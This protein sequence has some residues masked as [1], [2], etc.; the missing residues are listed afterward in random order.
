MEEKLILLVSEHP[1]LYQMTSP[2]YHNVNL[3]N[4]AW[5]N[6]SF[7]VGLPVEKCRKKWKYLRDTYKREKNEEK[8]R[9]RSGSGAAGGNR[10]WKFMSILNFLEPYIQDRDTSSNFS[11]NR[12]CEED[13]SVEALLESLVTPVEV[14]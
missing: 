1:C 5:R 8:E 2:D 14:V 7:A 10:R 9:K 4:N 12:T 11:Q 6:I 13:V 3:K